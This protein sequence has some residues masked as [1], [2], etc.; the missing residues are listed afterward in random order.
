MTIWL[1]VSLLVM[2]V[3]TVGPWGDIILGHT[4]GGWDT[5]GGPTTL[6]F[7]VLI[8]GF[9]SLAA[10]FPGTPKVLR[11]VMV[12]VA[13][14]LALLMAT[15]AVYWAASIQNLV[16]DS[17]GVQGAGW[18][19]W[20]TAIGAV[21]TLLATIGLTVATARS[22][23]VATARSAQVASGTGQPA[24]WYPDPNAAGTQ[25]YWDG[26]QWTEHTSPA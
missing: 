10:F 20:V 12:G 1:G 17:A 25:R 26:G 2:L 16:S 19:V 3:G 21:S 23:Q 4:V 11:L 18:G 15:L 7:A 9:S 22:P 8:L 13:I 24:G 14:F 5:S 6:V